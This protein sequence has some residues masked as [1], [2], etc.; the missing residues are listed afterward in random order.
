MTFRILLLFLFIGTACSPPPAATPTI[1]PPTD[2]PQ[3]QFADDEAFCPPPPNWYVYVTEA[4]DTLRD[5]ADQTGSSVG[6]LAM[7]NCLQNPRALSSGRVIYL[8]RRPI[9]S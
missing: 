8:P 5:L 6:E 9:E 7:A 2:L 3:V 4:G 1:A